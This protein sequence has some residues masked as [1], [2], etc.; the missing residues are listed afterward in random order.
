[1]VEN[2][3]THYVFKTAEGELHKGFIVNGQE[4]EQD[5][6]R[7]RIYLSIGI[8]KEERKNG[9]LSIRRYM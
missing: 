9:T 6:L 8:T 2:K 5:L 3:N 1:M 4:L 7:E